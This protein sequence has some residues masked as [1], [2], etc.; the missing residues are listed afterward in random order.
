MSM[1][2]RTFFGIM[3]LMISIRMCSLSRRVQD[4]HIRK[5]MLNNTH[6]SSSQEFEEVSSVFRTMALSADTTTAT[7]ISHARRLPTHLVNASI[8]L[9]SFRSDCK[10]SPPPIA[11][12]PSLLHRSAAAAYP[13]SQH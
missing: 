1:P 8:P 5:T 6:C 7:R 11:P 4:E 12:L 9:L 2:S 10:D 13:P 3:L